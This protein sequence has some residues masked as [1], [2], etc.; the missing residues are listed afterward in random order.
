MSYIVCYNIHESDE[1]KKWSAISEGRVHRYLFAAKEVYAHS[2]H[3][4][5][6]VTNVNEA[7]KQLPHQ[8][9]DGAYLSTSHAHYK[10]KSDGDNHSTRISYFAPSIVSS[11]I[12]ESH[13]DTIN[14]LFS[15]MLGVATSDRAQLEVYIKIT[16]YKEGL[17]MTT[18]AYCDNIIASDSLMCNGGTIVSDHYNKS[19]VREGVYIAMCGVTSDMIQLVNAYFD[20][21]YKKIISIDG[22]ADDHGRVYRIGIDKNNMFWKLEITGELCAI[23]SGSDHAWTAMDLGCSAADAVRMAIK[24]DTGTGGKIRTHRVR[25]L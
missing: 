21:A 3:G 13:Q 18:I 5:H 23:G 12:Y 8:S 11:E 16:V 14:R 7:I 10:Y 24:R 2:H 4:K 20:E 19:M 6:K 15:S 17:L 22:I 25:K 1:K 9:L